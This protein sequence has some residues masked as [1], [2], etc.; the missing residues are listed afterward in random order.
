[1]GIVA[2]SLQHVYCRMTKM[3]E[4]HHIV[5]MHPVTVTRDYLLAISGAAKRALRHLNDATTTR[6]CSYFLVT[7]AG[8]DEITRCAARSLLSGLEK[9]ATT[10]LTQE[11]C[12]VHS[13]SWTDY[14]VVCVICFKL[15]VM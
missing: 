14:G 1:M 7:G 5:M 8:V 3:S 2:L 10:P 12:S 15:C 4:T 6:K 13:T 11:Q 9:T